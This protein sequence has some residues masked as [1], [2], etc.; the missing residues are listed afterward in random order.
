MNR[1][2]RLL[3]FVKCPGIGLSAL[4]LFVAVLFGLAQ[5]PYGKRAFVVQIS[6]LLS[7]GETTRVEIGPVHGFFPFDLRL[8]HVLISDAHG[9][10]ISLEGLFL[11]WDPLSLLKG[12]RVRV[13]Q[14]GA[15]FVD[16][17]RVPA[18]E[19][20]RPRAQNEVPF[21]VKASLWLR[22]DHLILR[23]IRVDEN[24]A[25]V[26]ALFCAEG[27][28]LIPFG[29]DEHKTSLRL[30]RVDGPQAF[31]D[32]NVVVRSGNR[33][34]LHCKGE[35][36]PNGLFGRALG[37]DGPI[38]LALNGEGPL[39]S[40][41]GE[42]RAGLGR[43]LQIQSRLGIRAAEDLEVTAQ[44]KG[45]TGSGLV[46]KEMEPWVIGESR[47][48]MALRLVKN[49][50]L[51]W[52]HLNLETP[53]VDIRL[54]G[55]PIDGK[56]PQSFSFALSCTDISPLKDLTGVVVNGMLNAEGRIRDSLLQPRISTSVKV[57]RFQMEP[58]QLGELDGQ[59]DFVFL[60]SPGPSR[61]QLRLTGE[62]HLREVGLKEPVKWPDGTV[63]WALSVESLS[64]GDLRVQ[65]LR[66]VGEKA[67]IELSGRTDAGTQVADFQGN[68]KI[69]DLKP[70]LKLFDLD[71]PPGIRL[72]TTLDGNLLNQTLSSK[73]SGTIA[74][75]EDS[76]PSLALMG[77]ELRF[78]G[79]ITLADYYRDLS[80]SAFAIE[81]DLGKLQL[82]GSLAINTLRYTGRWRLL[83]PQLS[84]LA[85]RFGQKM[86]GRVELEGETRGSAS[87]MTLKVLASAGPLEI[88][89]VQIQ[90]ATATIHAVGFP[91]TFK[92]DMDLRLLRDSNTLQG[93]ADF[94]LGADR[95]QLSRIK[96]AGEESE[97]T[98]SVDLD[99]QRKLVQGSL[100]GRS[101][102]LLRVSRF[103]GEKIHGKASVKTQFEMSDADQRI[104]FDLV[105]EELNS[106]FGRAEKLR[107]QGTASQL[108][109][110]M[111]GRIRMD[112]DGFDHGDFSLTSL[113]LKT[114]GHIRR[115]SFALTAKGRYNETFHF[116][117]SGVIMPHLENRQLAIDR[118]KG[119]YAGFPVELDGRL[120]A[121]QRH[122][123]VV[124]EKFSF[125]TEAGYFTGSG[126]AKTDS[127]EMA[128]DFEGLPIAQV[129]FLNA[130]GVS[131]MARG[132][133]RLNGKPAH[134][135][136]SLEF[137]VEK[138]L[139]K[140]SPSLNL[141]PATFEARAKLEKQRLQSTFVL[142]GLTQ[143]PI[144]A[145][146]D[147]PFTLSVYPFQWSFPSEGVLRG[148]LDG[149]VDLSRFGLLDSLDDQQFAGNLHLLLHLGGTWA[150]PKIEGH[151]RLDNGSYENI[152]IGTILKNLSLDMMPETTRLR[153][154]HASADDG[155]QGKIS[156]QGWLDISPV[157]KFPF[158]IE[159]NLD[160]ATLIRHD[161][162][163]ARID[164]KLQ[165][166]GSLSGALLTGQL[167]LGPAEIRIPDRLPQ[168][169]AEMK[170][171]EVNGKFGPATDPP[172]NDP[173]L[174]QNLKLDVSLDSPGQIFVRGRG[175]DSEWKSDVKVGGTVA[176]PSISG[177]LTVVRG[178]FSFLAKRFE[179]KNGL[180]SFRGRVPPS[181]AIDVTAEAR[182]KDLVARLHLT[183]TLDSLGLSLASEPELP[184][185][186]VLSRLLFGRDASRIS[187]WQALTLASAVNTLSVGGGLDFMGKA[188]KLVGVDQLEIKQEEDDIYKSKIS[189]GKHLNEQVYLQVERGLD[190]GSGEA[191]VEIEITPNF[192][193][194]TEVTENQEAG[195]GLNWKWD[196]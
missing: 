151:V 10:W 163:N 135:N 110:E 93:R 26:G 56:H 112:L 126:K 44:G 82:D 195:I 130:A 169:I 54:K 111:K 40:W 194:E 62:G 185:D 128:L 30:S 134:P 129:P 107:L 48:D 67:S 36:A 170:V 125:N 51:L 1:Q 116:E 33:L 132:R 133:L 182:R 28:A 179:L 15:D 14:L 178:H 183:G 37:V 154:V 108:T 11:R 29:E 76:P 117:T 91:P 113:N 31:L 32:L 84:L 13:E 52:D 78:G 2:K 77:H 158:Q 137:S 18:A 55:D 86:K 165:F 70:F 90:G 8:E 60:N 80:A 5:T 193:I 21:W 75:S 88:H 53:S 64:G 196:Y 153:F 49:E 58:I 12:S 143:T 148:K 152:R 68:I 7:T 3:L 34:I 187:P 105:A 71:V 25:G 72:K 175:L 38:R 59:L 83:V 9:P 81:S 141:P 50:K 17:L 63:Q 22:V 101:E 145:M 161:Y 23:K 16:M 172:S 164:G 188:R 109:K 4:F 121:V 156:A 124:F 6:R 46:P 41:E 171:V 94:I 99:F 39:D 147:V 120:R 102:N 19:A 136:G 73:V 180:I 43:Q 69:G 123:E 127:C 118:F 159:L 95:L 106:R 103:L 87:E 189:A 176:N 89:N 167:K 150:Q 47:F 191:V 100:E 79:K 168:D 181:P 115:L 61:P 131:G 85:S 142:S 149:Q 97:I 144:G 27:M 65:S 174:G 162:G 57:R 20:R 119:T 24:V 190:Y 173:P 157:K 98:G 184:Q 140:E 177:E 139:T 186:E 42:L 74:L 96:A 104:S 92:G 122:D 114:D 138:L 35:E 160:R 192:S 66:L 155:E 166:S 146:V 45:L